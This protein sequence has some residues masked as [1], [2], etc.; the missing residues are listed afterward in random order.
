MTKNWK[1][2]LTLLASLTLTAAYADNQNDNRK[3][4]DAI[5]DDQEVV[6][7]LDEIGDD[8]GDDLDDDE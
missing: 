4:T 8:L 2:M 5:D 7:N 1:W 3:E 6:I